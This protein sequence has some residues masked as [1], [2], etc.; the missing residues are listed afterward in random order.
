MGTQKKQTKS[1]KPGYRPQ[2]PDIKDRAFSPEKEKELLALVTN[3]AQPLCETQGLEL[4]HVEYQREA[5]G[6]ILRIY[7]DKPGGIKLDDCV[8]VS[9]QLGD[10]LDV[11]I[12]Q[13]ISY[14]LEVS[15]PGLD[16][17]LGKESDYERFKGRTIMIK[18]SQPFDGKKKYQGILKGISHDMSGKAVSILVNDKK[19]LIPYELINRARLVNNNG[20]NRC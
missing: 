10:L 2:K 1:K 7:I 13:N 15:S 18:T 12:E 19:V 8:C 11:S 5:Q 14:N 9:R 20:E 17:P 16:R 6:R 4:V 3:L